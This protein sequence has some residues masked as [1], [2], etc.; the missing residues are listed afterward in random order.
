MVGGV[1]P[2]P[3]LLPL[4][5]FFPSNIVPGIASSSKLC[6]HIAIHHLDCIDCLDNNMAPKR[7]ESSVD[8]FLEATDILAEIMGPVTSRMAMPPPTSPA[9]RT[10]PR[11]ATATTSST[12]TSSSRQAIWTGDK[13]HVKSKVGVDVPE[14]RTRSPR[15]RRRLLGQLKKLLHNQHATEFPVEEIYNKNNETAVA[16]KTSTNTS[17]PVKGPAFF[18]LTKPN[19][20]MIQQTFMDRDKRGNLLLKI[21]ANKHNVSD[22]CNIRKIQTPFRLCVHADHIP[23]LG[24]D[25]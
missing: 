14:Y 12:T 18:Y 20:A 22:I 13:L 2:V 24:N 10:S 25:T 6:S 17:T 15:Q 4:L 5:L 11:P 3:G 16:N 21:R 8:R 1:Y 9:S 23:R 19:G 7:T